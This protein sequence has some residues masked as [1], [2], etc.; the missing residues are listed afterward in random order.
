MVVVLWVFAC[1]FPLDIFVGV[2][3][4]YS[5]WGLNAADAPL[6]PR[7]A[8]VPIERGGRRSRAPPEEEAAADGFG[9]ERWAGGDGAERG[10]V[11]ARGG[12]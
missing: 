1:I 2:D 3:R 8:A 11:A 7:E 9:S 5:K 6:Q 10:R 12:L 4:E